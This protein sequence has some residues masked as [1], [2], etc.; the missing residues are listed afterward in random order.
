MAKKPLKGGYLQIQGKYHS[1][2]LERKSPRSWGASLLTKTYAYP[3]CQLRGVR[4]KDLPDTDELWRDFVISKIIRYNYE[5][6]T[7]VTFMV[8]AQFGGSDPGWQNLWIGHIS[9]TEVLAYCKR[10]A[11]ER[12]AEEYYN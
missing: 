2:T 3:F 6:R 8:S 7:D 10:K 1:E 4:L 5:Y 11:R 12:E 9:Y